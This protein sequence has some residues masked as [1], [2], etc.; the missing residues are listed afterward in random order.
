MGPSGVLRD[1]LPDVPRPIL[2]R[3]EAPFSPVEEH[4][5]PEHKIFTRHSQEVRT[6]ARLRKMQEIVSQRIFP[7][8]PGTFSGLSY[9]IEAASRTDPVYRERV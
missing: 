5:V 3:D 4:P 7:S 9:R 6:H 8:T 1:V 2:T